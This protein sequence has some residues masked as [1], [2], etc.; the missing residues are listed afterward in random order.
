M[1]PWIIVA[2]FTKETGYEKEA[3]KLVN[4]I[5][6][7][8]NESGFADYEVVGITNLGDWNKNT[9][10][11]PVFIKKMLDKYEKCNIV[12]VDADA[13]ILNY[14]KFFDNLDCDFACHFRKKKSQKHLDQPVGYIVPEYEL[15]SGTLYFANND[16]SRLL[17]S[18]WEKRCNQDRLTFDQRLL[19]QS[20]KN[21]ADKILIR[22]KDLPPEYCKIKG[23]MS[24]E[25]SEAV[26]L[27]N[28]A[29]KK[30]KDKKTGKVT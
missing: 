15:L 28:Q 6:K 14:P 23:Q 16:K 9:H 3:E 18:N 26:I 2:Y 4:S 29:S 8:N 27:H 7:I 30:L 17:I 5:K 21:V 12:Y 25:D 20:L 1:K 22:I 19:H 24:I 10:H 11:K 13:Q